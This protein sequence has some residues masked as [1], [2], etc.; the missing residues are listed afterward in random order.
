MTN[1]PQLEAWMQLQDVFLQA[2]EAAS[3]VQA[4]ALQ[5]GFKH[6]DASIMGRESFQFLMNMMMKQQ[7]KEMAG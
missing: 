7:E 1:D 6:E 5:A 4:S 3:G 2:V